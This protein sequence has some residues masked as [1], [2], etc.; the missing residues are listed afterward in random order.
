MLSAVDPAALEAALT[1]WVL[2]RRP[3][4]PDPEQPHRPAA[5]QREVLAVDG[6]ILR[7]TRT[8]DDTPLQSAAV[9][10][11]G[12]RLTLT[13]AAV[14]GGDEIAAFTAVLDTLPDLAGVLIT[15][16]ALHTQRAHA[17]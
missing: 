15:A 17:E 11:H 14:A 13:Q 4:V 6:K 16:D 2:S 1:R 8:G 12:G 7:G 3:A 10:D 9:F 5:E